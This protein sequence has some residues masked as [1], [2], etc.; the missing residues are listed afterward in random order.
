MF[1]NFLVLSSWIPQKFALFQGLP[2]QYSFGNT[3]IAEHIG[4]PRLRK[5]LSQQEWESTSIICT[6]Y[7]ESEIY[8]VER[9]WSFRK[10]K[11]DVQCSMTRT[12][13]DF[14]ETKWGVKWV[15]GVNYPRAMGWQTDLRMPPTLQSE[16]WEP[17][18]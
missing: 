5:H 10:K 18:L 9:F 7:Q 12:V 3:Q 2:D 15:R 14:S 17:I 4:L 1:G 8:I 13:D 11:N 16:N 6:A